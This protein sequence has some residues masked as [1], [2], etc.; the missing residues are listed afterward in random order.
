VCT[1]CQTWS[2]LLGEPACSNCRDVESALGHP[3][4]PLSVMTLYRKPSMLRDWLTYYKGCPEEGVDPNRAHGAV[5]SDLL[6]D[7]FDIHAQ[8]LSEVTKG[9]DA[10]VVVPSTE[11]PPPHALERVLESIVGPALA[12]DLLVR[13]SAPLGFRAPSVDG[14]RVVAAVPRPRR[15]LIVDDVYTTGARINSAA[16]ALRAEGICVVGAFVIARRVNPGYGASAQTFW[17][18]QSAKPFDLVT[19]PYLQGVVS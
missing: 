16:Y 8:R 2:D 4:T 9:Y 5:I 13:G 12:R 6:A 1:I 3:A 7:F 18:R 19:S 11:H 17:D 15:V 14:Y 10:I